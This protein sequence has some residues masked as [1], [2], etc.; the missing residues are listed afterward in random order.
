MQAI[1]Q[2]RRTWEKN[3]L[4]LILILAAI[5]RVLAAFFSRGYGMQDD[6]FLVIEPAQAWADGINYQE[7]LPWGR[8][9]VVPDGHSLFYSGLHYLLFLFFNTIRLTD[10]QLK[11]LIVRLLHATFSL[12]VVWYGYKITLRISGQKEAS[13]AGLLLALLWFM[14]MLSVRNLVEM[15]CIPFMM[16][17]TWKLLI[18]DDTSRPWLSYLLGGIIMG[19]GFSIR[20]QT[21][22]FI[23]GAGLALLLMKRWLPAFIFGLG[24]LLAI[25]PVQGLIDF[26]IWGYPFAEFREYV[27]YNL[28]AANDYVTGPW[29]NYLLL[30]A[31]IL[32]PP[33]SLFLIAGFFRLWRKQLLIFLPAFLFLLFHSF[34]PNK[35]ERF[36]F[37]VIPFFVILGVAGWSLILKNSP[38]WISRRMLIKRSWVFFWI[39]NSAIL[40]VVSVAYSKRSQVEAMS[41]LSKYKDLKVILS[42]NSNHDG[43]R[44]FPQFYLGQWIEIVSKSRDTI[45]TYSPLHDSVS[46]SLKNARFVMF[47][48]TGNLDRRLESLKKELPSLV[49]ET[50]INPGFVDAVMFRLNPVNLNQTIIIYRNQALVPKKILK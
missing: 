17:G 31:G 46:E 9:N 10:P 25:L 14:P 34:F 36:I 1:N 40:L 23:G 16:A 12:G 30:L 38:F 50:T 4:S 45:T 24:A 41:Y 26:R 15:V 47:S 7:W 49:Y 28:Q 44:M 18:A 21:V 5:F 39:I 20:F 13:L 27:I 37:P 33:V 35:Q 43:Y 3:P 22:I 6:H 2:L 8:S 48:E 19:I 42:E 11:M 32:L 29:Y